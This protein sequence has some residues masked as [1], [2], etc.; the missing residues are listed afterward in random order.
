MMRLLLILLLQVFI[1]VPVLHDGCRVVRLLI[2]VTVLHDGCHGATIVPDGRAQGLHVGE[3]H[4][5]EVESAGALQRQIPRSRAGDATTPLPHQDLH[6]QLAETRDGD[7]GSSHVSDPEAHREHLPVPRDEAHTPRRP[8][9]HGV[10]CGRAKADGVGVL[11]GGLVE[12]VGAAH[13]LG[14]PAVHEHLDV[15]AWCRPALIGLL[16]DRQDPPRAVDEVVLVEACEGA[17]LTRSGGHRGL[18]RAALIGGLESEDGLRRPAV[19]LSVAPLSAPNAVALK[20]LRPFL[21]RAALAPS[22]LSIAVLA[23]LAS[24]LPGLPLSVLLVVQSVHLHGLGARF[25][26]VPSAAGGDE[27]LDGG[28]DHA[29]RRQALGVDQEMGA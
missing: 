21:I 1:A 6:A 3:A 28:A 11:L 2:A 26:R 27:R 14:G 20:L 12:V 9:G 10:P 5:E 18:A 17:D 7:D 23:L 13:V 29:V 22:A 16:A 4:V 24:A 25:L 8:R 19:S 15:G